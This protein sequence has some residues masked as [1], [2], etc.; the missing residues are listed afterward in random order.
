MLKRLNEADIELVAKMVLEFKETDINIEKTLDYLENRDNYL[1]GFIEDEKVV[2]FISAYSIQRYDGKGN[3][4]Y[5][6]E[7]DIHENYRLKGIGSAL[8]NELK[9]VCKKESYMKMFVITNKSNTGAVS[10][11][12]STDGKSYHNDD[13]VYTFNSDSF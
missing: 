3:M 5:I 12:K 9:L 13:I 2:G 7:V 1:I 11:Y 8:I 10:L 4:M 6:H